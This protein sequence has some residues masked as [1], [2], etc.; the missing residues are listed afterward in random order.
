MAS[1]KI[2][3]KFGVFYRSQGRWTG[4]YRGITRAFRTWQR[5]T[6]QQDLAILKNN[7]LK[8]RIQLRQ[9]SP[10]VLG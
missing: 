3:P 7:I 8:S 4:P 9:V 5:K 2:T 10:A 6:T 1:K